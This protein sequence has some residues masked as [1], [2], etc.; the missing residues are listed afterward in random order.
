MLCAHRWNLSS[1][2]S[3]GGVKVLRSR[4]FMK[5]VEVIISGTPD[6]HLAL[7]M[8]KVPHIPCRH[9]C[10]KLPFVQPL[11]SPECM[12]YSARRHSLHMG[13]VEG[14]ELHVEIKDLTP[15]GN[16][17]SSSARRGGDVTTSALTWFSAI[18]WRARNVRRRRG[19]DTKLRCLFCLGG[20]IVWQHGCV[21]EAGVTRV[22][23]NAAPLNM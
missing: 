5:I 14:V 23:R 20:F 10:L 18:G 8:K 7:G 21:C 9:V 15:V 6:W 22:T 3:S 2:A 13:G 16:K 19:L 4:L 11:M 17:E 12:M 1:A